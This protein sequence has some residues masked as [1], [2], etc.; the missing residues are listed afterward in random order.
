MLGLAVL[1]ALSVSPSHFFFFF[2]FCRSDHVHRFDARVFV[3]P[4]LF[5]S[6]TPVSQVTMDD[7]T[8]AK[9]KALY[10]KKGNV[11]EGLYL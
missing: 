3:F 1:C 10:R 5:L 8:K 9:E 11:P 4:R 6:F 2:C 7:F